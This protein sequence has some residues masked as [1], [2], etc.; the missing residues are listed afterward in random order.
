VVALVA[1]AVVASD[2]LAVYVALL[3]RE[4]EK[5]GENQRGVACARASDSGECGGSQPTG[6]MCTPHVGVASRDR[7]S[8]ARRQ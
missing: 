4:G 1:V 8:L 6:R 3:G 2:Y 7:K 5:E